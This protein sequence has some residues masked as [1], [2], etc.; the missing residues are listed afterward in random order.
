MKVKKSLG[1]RVKIKQKEIAA[2]YRPDF[3][4]N[5]WFCV[6]S[7]VCIH[8]SYLMQWAAVMTQLAAIRDPPQVCL[9]APSF[10]YCRE[11]WRQRGGYTHTLCLSNSRNLI[12][13]DARAACQRH[14]PVNDYRWLPPPKFTCQGQLWGLASSPFTTREV[15]GSM[16]GVPH[17]RAAWKGDEIQKWNTS[18]QETNFWWTSSL[19]WWKNNSLLAHNHLPLQKSH[20]DNIEN[21]G[22]PDVLTASNENWS[23]HDGKH[24]DGCFNLGTQVTH[25][26]TRAHMTL[27]KL[28]HHRQHKLQMW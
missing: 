16:A 27:F 4:Y 10:S 23:Q 3:G 6:F 2:W 28:F 1:P 25:T 12:Y 9:H 15:R 13:G 21:S 26:Q 20:W 8:S 17:P 18:W 14:M 5:V 11:I 24:A 19:F 7:L 22:K